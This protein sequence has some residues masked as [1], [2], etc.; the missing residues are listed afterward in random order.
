MNRLGR[1]GGGV[2]LRRHA[3]ELFVKSCIVHREP[4]EKCDHDIS[5]LRKQYPG[6]PRTSSTSNAARHQLEEVEEVLGGRAGIEDLSGNRIR[7]T[8]A[9][10]QAGT[11][12]KGWYFFALEAVLMLDQRK[13]T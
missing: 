8:G 10:R 6:Y 9:W 12:P 1:G 2:L 7:S 4:V 3:V 11:V 5:G 13:T